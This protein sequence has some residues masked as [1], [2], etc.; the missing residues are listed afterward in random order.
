[1]EAIDHSNNPN[2]LRAGLA[3]WAMA[4]AILGLCVPLVGIAGLVMG[5]VAF[6]GASAQP[7]KR[8]GKGYAIAAMSV[9]GLAT[10]LGCIIVPMMAGILL[11]ALSK[12]REAAMQIRTD[13]NLRQ[14]G[15]A[16]G[17][18]A[19]NNNDA[20]PPAD[21]WAQDLV[22]GGYVTSDVFED[23]YKSGLS[24]WMYYVPGQ[25]FDFDASMPLVY[26]A[27]GYMPNGGGIILYGDMHTEYLSDFD[28]LPAISGIILPDGTRFAPHEGVDQG[29]HPGAPQ[30]P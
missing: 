3:I 24:E 10:L 7:P 14:I 30:I 16:L 5:I 27:P 23:L 13:M 20:F 17:A 22:S 21:T 9:G 29:G 8:G 15:A 12:A 28:F 11:P 2:Q 26:T 18:Y 6:T 19:N 25:S 1:M 4:L